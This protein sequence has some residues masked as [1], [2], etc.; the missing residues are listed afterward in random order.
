MN[1]S[2]RLFGHAV[3]IRPPALPAPA[4]VFTLCLLSILSYFFLYILDS[5]TLLATLAPLA[6]PVP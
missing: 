6:L 1:S 5:H 3:W 2:R 4:I